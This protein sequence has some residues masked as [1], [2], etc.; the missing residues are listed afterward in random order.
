MKVHPTITELNGITTVTMSGQFIGDSTDVS[1]R[2]LITAYGDPKVNL[3]GLFTDPT[4]EQFQ[5]Q[6][7]A[8]EVYAGV[9][10]TMASMPVRFM[11]A[12]PVTIT[13]GQCTPEQGPLDC[14][15]PDPAHAATVWS[16]VIQTRVQ[17]AMAALRAQVPVLTS[18]PDLTV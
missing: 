2:A 4:Q 16:E 1:D 15:T 17:Q 13:Y 11:V 9:T 6:F 12:F 3:A 8:S 18:L 14:I 10:T 7:P 5:F